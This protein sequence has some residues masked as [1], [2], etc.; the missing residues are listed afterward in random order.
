MNAEEQYTEIVEQIQTEIQSVIFSCEVKGKY[1][2]Q[3]TEEDSIVELNHFIAACDFL[4]HE[5]E[6]DVECDL[7]GKKDWCLKLDPEYFGELFVIPSMSQEQVEELAEDNEEGVLNLSLT[8]LVEGKVLFIERDVMFFPSKDEVALTKD[9]VLKFL[10]TPPFDGGGPWYCEGGIFLDFVG[11]WDKDKFEEN[12]PEGQEPQKYFEDLVSGL[13]DTDEGLALEDLDEKGE[14]VM[15]KHPQTGSISGFL[16]YE[17][18][19]DFFC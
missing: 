19:E 2:Q 4:G 5:A 9:A 14:C 8:A 15:F 17:E 11:K 7:T 3:E 16:Q 12:C 1:E 10:T 6:W 13:Y 18:Y